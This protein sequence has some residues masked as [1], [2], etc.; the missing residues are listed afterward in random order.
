M[1]TPSATSHAEPW[2][3][4]PCVRLT[5]PQGDNLLVAE[6]GAQVL[7]WVA[8]GRER[9]FLS[10]G[11]VADGR[12]P[13][14]GGVPVC[15]PQFNQSGPL[16]K[17]GFARNLAWRLGAF[18]PGEDRAELRMHLGADAQTLTLW[19]H[20][21]EVTLVLRLSPGRLQLALDVHNPGDTNWSFT[22]ALHSYLRVDDVTQVRLLGLEGQAEWDALHHKEARAA[23]SIAIDGPFDRV[24][25][26]APEPLRLSEGACELR[27]SQSA[28]WAHT[29][30]WNPGT[31]M[32][33]LPD[34]TYRQ[35]L[36]VEAAQ[37]WS[38]VTVAAGGHW[39]GWQQ[40]DVLCG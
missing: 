36:C 38:P 30:V 35:M 39:A 5:L 34:Q 29:V 18:V 20:R 37:A 3:G 1:P 14:R 7:S 15:W 40:F 8:A 33:D 19:P 28:T 17:H 24:Y 13:I 16:T 23:A 27:L 25:T 31:A 26:A 2:R 22:G 4:L 10:P 21:F 6:Q 12:T 11:S 32:P 9:L